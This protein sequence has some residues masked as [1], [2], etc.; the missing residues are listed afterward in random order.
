MSTWARGANYT[1]VKRK[2]ASD[3]PYAFARGPSGVS[4]I[5]ASLLIPGCISSGSSQCSSQQQ[6]AQ[7]GNARQHQVHDTDDSKVGDRA[8]RMQSQ[9]N[10][11]A[12]QKIRCD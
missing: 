3:Q 11:A 2:A 10:Q 9:P 7:N 1:E 4:I 12:G 8:R 6:L 5:G